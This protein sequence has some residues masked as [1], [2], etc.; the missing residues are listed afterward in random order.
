M[1]HDKRSFLQKFTESICGCTPDQWMEADSSRLHQTMASVESKGL[2]TQEEADAMNKTI[3]QNIRKTMDKIEK[4]TMEE[5]Q[6]TPQDEP[7][8][9]KVKTF[10]QKLGKWLSELL[11]FA[12][13][14]IREILKWI[15]EQFQWC[16][17]MTKELCIFLCSLFKSE[18]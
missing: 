17:S 9:I 1:V 13:E 11:E 2:T 12:S 10:A 14:K 16:C 15:K 3:W 4:N 8:E 7:E 18:Q 6:I 5:L